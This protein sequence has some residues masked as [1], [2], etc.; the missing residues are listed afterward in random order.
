MTHM[1][2]P[3]QRIPQIPQTVPQEE[4]D[5]LVAD[6]QRR[7][8]SRRAFIQRSVALGLSLSAASALLAACGGGSSGGGGPTTLS[9]LTTWGGEEQDSFKAVVAPFT[10]R[11]GIKVNI[12][13]TRDLDAQLTILLRGN[14]P[15]DI[16]ILPN[17]G[18]MQQLAS[19][20]KLIALDSFLDMNQV[21]NDYAKSWTDLGSSNGK[22]YAIFFK[23]ANK[24]TVWYS[25]K[26]FQTDGYQTPASWQ[27]MI[28]LSN[29]IAGKGKF[30]WSMGVE[31]GAASGWPATD[32]VAEILVNQ[33]GPDTYDKWVAHQIPWTDA[34]VKNAFQYFGQIAHGNHYINGAP[35]SILATGFEP[36]SYGPFKSPPDSYMYYLGDF[37][38]GFI[39]KQFKS[40]QPQTDF[41]FFPFPTISDQ[42]KGAITVGADVVVAMKDN[43]SVHQ[44]VKYL[45]T[46]DAQTIWVK[47]GGF[48][49]VNKNVP[50]SDYPDPVAQAS[51]QMLTGA[52]IVK[53]GAGD[54][55]PSQ[56]QAAFWKGMLTYIQDQG[57]LDSVLST[58]ESTAAT[59][60]K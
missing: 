44:L 4:L 30:P 17:P 40:L 31:S 11:T 54:L 14:N 24:G 7:G 13:A 19:Q 49:A 48:T 2:D 29:T 45:A 21:H 39:T 46:A 1:D 5:D 10:Q 6:Y 56:V 36:A 60:Y 57:Q 47:R 34:S 18:K 51:V 25:P 15:P 22:L 35:Q 32:W 28:N 12:T 33:S 59:A 38:Q 23:A 20:H 53:Y 3:Q 26:Q 16:A 9:L 58:I 55:M 43:D 42:N 50:V 27:D 37:A 52:P 41:N 8:V